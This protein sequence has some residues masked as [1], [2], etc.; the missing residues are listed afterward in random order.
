MIYVQLA[1]G[2]TMR[3][4]HRDLSILDFPTRLRQNYSGC[5]RS[6]ARRDQRLAR[7]ASAFRCERI[8]NLAANGAPLCCSHHPAFVITFWFLV[9]GR[10]RRI[11]FAPKFIE[12]W[13]FLVL[14]QITLGAWTIWSNKAADIATAHVAIGAIMLC[15][16]CEHLV[17]ICIR[18][19][20]T[21][22]PLDRYHDRSFRKVSLLMKTASVTTSPASNQVCKVASSPISPNW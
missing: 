11:G 19:A 18:L 5:Q 15:S 8:S 3:H 20:Q 4:Q 22:L 7:C 1:L 13:L 2:A 14:C 21:S 10:V 12:L 17:A 16:G 9:R 6:K